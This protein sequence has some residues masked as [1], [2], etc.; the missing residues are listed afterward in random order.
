MAIPTSMLAW[1][2][3]T[4]PRTIR[5]VYPSPTRTGVPGIQDLDTCGADL[6]EGSLLAATMT[7]EGG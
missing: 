5:F 7:K 2:V 1:L 4:R 3:D 6:G